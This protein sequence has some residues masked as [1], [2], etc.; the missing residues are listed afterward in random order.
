MFHHMFEWQK[1]PVATQAP[2]CNQTPRTG[3]AEALSKEINLAMDQVLVGIDAKIQDMEEYI[4][5]KLLD[6]LSDE[7]KKCISGSTEQFEADLGCIT[8]ALKKL[9]SNSVRM[10]Q[11]SINNISITQETDVQKLMD[12]AAGWAVTDWYGCPGV[13]H[14]EKHA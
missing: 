6:V 13:D 9:V 11:V 1:G 14:E 2:S 10:V 12:Q 3:L 8:E 5:I 4:K 7:V